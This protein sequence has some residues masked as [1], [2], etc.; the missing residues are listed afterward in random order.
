ML[1]A[2]VLRSSLV[3]AFCFFWGGV[4]GFVQ[5][6]RNMLRNGVLQRYAC[7]NDNTKGGTMSLE[8]IT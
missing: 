2:V 3:L 1:V 4:R 6:L 8:I 5:V 7:V